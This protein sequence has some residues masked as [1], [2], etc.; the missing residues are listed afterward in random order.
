MA[1]LWRKKASIA[2]SR[3]GRRPSRDPEPWPAAPEALAA[4]MRAWTVTTIATALFV[5]TLGASQVWDKA[6]YLKALQDTFSAESPL[7]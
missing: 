1:G 6:I 7:M 4:L 5:A 2:A 3:T